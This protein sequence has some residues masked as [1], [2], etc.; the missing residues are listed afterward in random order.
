MALDFEVN[1]TRKR[2]R[3]KKTWLRAVVEQSRNVGLNE[4]DANNCSRCRLGVDTISS[5]MR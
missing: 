3:P 4:Y 1:G 2:G 5:K